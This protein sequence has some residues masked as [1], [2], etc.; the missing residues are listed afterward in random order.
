MLSILSKKLFF[1]LKILI[2]KNFLLAFFFS[3][4][5]YCSKRWLKINP[6]VYNINL[7]NKNL[8]TLFDISGRKL[9]LI[10]ELGP[11]IEYLVR[12]IFLEKACKTCAVKSSHFLILVKQP[13]T[14]NSYQ[15]LLKIRYFERELSK[16]LNKVN[17]I[18]SCGTQSVF[19]DKIMINKREKIT[20]K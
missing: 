11:L 10:I 18:F 14:T 5:S 1:V 19:L 3:S 17:L 13:K 2:F 20:K 8:N 9:R 16:N 6:E 4:V 7:L 12:N 15:K